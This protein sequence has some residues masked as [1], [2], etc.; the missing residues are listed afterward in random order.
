MPGRTFPGCSISCWRESARIGKLMMS[1]LS[2]KEGQE[3]ELSGTFNLK[4]ICYQDHRHWRS[5]EVLYYHQRF[6]GKLPTGLVQ[7]SWES[8]LIRCHLLQFQEIFT[9]RSPDDGAGPFRVWC[10]LQVCHM[11]PRVYSLKFGGIR[12]D[13]Q[14]LIGASAVRLKRALLEVSFPVDEIFRFQGVML[15]YFVSRECTMKRLLY[16]STVIFIFIYLFTYLFI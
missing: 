1:C 16:Q 11:N 8:C 13:Q 3:G 14:Y 15:K 9:F 7:I 12:V 10:F 6:G 2:N 5:S 4:S